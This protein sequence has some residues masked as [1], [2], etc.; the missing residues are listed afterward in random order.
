MAV[1]IIF[2]LSLLGIIYAYFG[3]PVALAIWA[4][5]KA[6]PVNRAV[7]NFYPEISIIIPAYNEEAVIEKKIENT[8]SLAYPKDKMELIVVSDGSS[9]DTNKI[10]GALAGKYGFN[11]IEVNKRQGK[12]NAVNAGLSAAT[13]DIII[14]SDSSIML[15]SKALEEIVK[16]FFDKKVGLISGEDHI[17][18]DN[19]GEG[20]YGQYE[21]FLRNQE[22]KTGSI[23]GASGSFYA[24]R[25]DL[26]LPFME[27][28]A[29]DF[30]SVLNTVEKGY[31]AITEPRAFGIMSALKS[32]KDEFHRKTRTLI[33][34]MT[35]LW[36]KRKLMNPVKYKGFA[37]VLISHKLMRWLVP[38]FMLFVFVAN[39][40][41]LHS[42]FYLTIFI[43]QIIFYAAAVFA[44]KEIINMN[45]K[46][47]GKIPL[48][49]CSVNYAI[50]YS[51][52]KYIL[53]A[54]QEIWEPTK[55]GS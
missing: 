27:G 20:L 55:R 33:R 40:F 41:L 34:G 51:W 43:I 17:P 11:F 30:L 5:L 28:L 13:A 14:F 25:K 18:D 38:F 6:M 7:D 54:R 31:R 3:Y 48:Y 39:I 15:D 47:Y 19:G 50:F 42:L 16:G 32:T 12:A 44:W 2:W 4:H 52:F 45:E 53:G 49:F 37:F 21:L 24:Q 29:P 23:V 9:D 35:T 26:C 8:L 36:Y 22:S 1:E 46:I 10:V